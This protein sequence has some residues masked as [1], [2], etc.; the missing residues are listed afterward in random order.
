[1]VDT[2]ETSLTAKPLAEADQSVQSSI[3]HLR[4]L[5]ARYAFDVRNRFYKNET[6]H[7]DG[8]T[9]TNCGFQNC[10]LIT[11]T[12]VFSLD[13]CTMINCTIHFGDNAHKIIKLYHAFG[14]SP[15]LAGYQPTIASD[16]T[17]TIR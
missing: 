15:E 9:F 8:Y 5:L 11:N 3:A 14:G 13:A 7:L 16:G 2:P 1:M 12:G 4:Q 6:I 17:L 10:S